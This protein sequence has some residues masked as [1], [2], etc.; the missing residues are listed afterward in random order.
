MHLLK[1]KSQ[2]SRRQK[3]IS[4]ATTYCRMG[5]GEREERKCRKGLHPGD[6]QVAVQVSQKSGPDDQTLRLMPGT[7]ELKTLLAPK[8]M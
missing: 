8:K 7:L 1:Y 4:R 6:H 2:A 5:L 3:W